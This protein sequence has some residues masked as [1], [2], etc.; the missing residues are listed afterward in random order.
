MSLKRTIS[1]PSCEECGDALAGATVDGRELCGSCAT[2]ALPTCPAC[3][4]AG[5][6]PSR[7][8]ATAR[9]LADDCRVARFMEVDDE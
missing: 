6:V 7:S 8:Y 5:F 9:C 1:A 4:A 3:G 2:E